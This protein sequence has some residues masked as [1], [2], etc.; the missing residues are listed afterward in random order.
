MHGEEGKEVESGE[1]GEVSVVCSYRVE[2][3]LWK[4]EQ[5]LQSEGTKRKG[6]TVKGMGWCSDLG[7]EV[8]KGRKGR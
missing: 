1:R 2:G 8:G 7:K 5:A 6:K 3:R 4:K